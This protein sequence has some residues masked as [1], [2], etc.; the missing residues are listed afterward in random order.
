[1]QTYSFL[2]ETSHYL[3]LLPLQFTWRPPCCF[4]ISPY[5]PRK[6]TLLA[7][8]PGTDVQGAPLA[9]CILQDLQHRNPPRHPQTAARGGQPPTDKPT[10]HISSPVNIYTHRHHC[11]GQLLLLSAISMPSVVIAKAGEIQWQ[12]SHTLNQHADHAILLSV[13]S[14]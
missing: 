4:W 3:A 12:K 7:M 10:D 8:C 2:L 6:H 9:C 1:M 11:L 14:A 5:T 13:R